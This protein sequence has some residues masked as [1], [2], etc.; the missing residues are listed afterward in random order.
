ME[1]KTIRRTNNKKG[2]GTLYTPSKCV[3]GLVRARTVDGHREKSVITIWCAAEAAHLFY[4]SRD[5][6][7]VDVRRKIEPIEAGCN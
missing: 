4:L 6:A 1:L 7:A 3:L 2:E 5:S